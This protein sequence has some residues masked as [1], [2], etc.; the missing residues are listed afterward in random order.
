MIFVALYFL[1]MISAAILLG[2]LWL[3]YHGL[4]YLWQQAFP[5]RRESGQKELKESITK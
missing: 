1:V 4:A 3:V 2:I 5:A